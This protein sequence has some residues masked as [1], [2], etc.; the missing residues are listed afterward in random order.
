MKDDH[1][2]RIELPARYPCQVA[3]AAE[4]IRSRIS[5]GELE[6]A[7]L[8]LSPRKDTDSQRTEK[9]SAGFSIFKLLL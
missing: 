4:A 9:N 1:R 5:Q 2:R 6:I 3:T 7:S 8:P